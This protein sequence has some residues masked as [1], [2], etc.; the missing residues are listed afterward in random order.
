MNMS[1]LTYC[2]LNMMPDWGPILG[3][4]VPER[5]DRL[6][7]PETRRYMEDRAASP[8]CR[9]VRPAHRLGHLR[10]R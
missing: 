9:R 8:G 7:D 6:R 5:I 2:A 10:H 1:F 4:P 3:L